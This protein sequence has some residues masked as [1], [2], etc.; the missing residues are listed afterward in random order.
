MKMKNKIP[1]GQYRN[2]ASILVS[3]CL[4]TNLHKDLLRKEIEKKKNQKLT[5][6]AV[7]VQIYSRKTLG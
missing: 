7:T 5:T 6:M 2:T 3:N 4:R 1:K